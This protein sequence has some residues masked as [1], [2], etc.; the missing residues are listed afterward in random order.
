M[1]Q[2]EQKPP[3]GRESHGCLSLLL[4][5]M[6]VPAEC[7]EK[8]RPCL[9]TRQTEVMRQLVGQGQG[10][11]VPRQRLIRIASVSTTSKPSRKGTSTPDLVHRE[12]SGHGAAGCRRGTIPCSRWAWAGANSPSQNIAPPE[13]AVGPTRGVQGLGHCWASVRNCSASSCAVWNSARWR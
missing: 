9:C 10:L 3:L 12:E 8:G 7:L 13:S 2:S 11:V 6:R 5:R 1:C 4:G